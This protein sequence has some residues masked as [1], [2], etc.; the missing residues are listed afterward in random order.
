MKIKIWTVAADDSLGTRATVHLAER[1]AY[2]LWLSLQAEGEAPDVVATGAA[3]IAREDYEGLWDWAEAAD[4]GD[5][6]D[7]YAIEEHEIDVPSSAGR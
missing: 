4:L 2:E 1:K 6:L 5:A 3:L 7:T